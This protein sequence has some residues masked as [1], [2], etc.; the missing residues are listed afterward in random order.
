[1]NISTKSPVI[2]ALANDQANESQRAPPD[3]ASAWRP[4]ADNLRAGL[5]A[6]LAAID[7]HLATLDQASR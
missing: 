6:L 4:C 2:L 1:M 5:P 7:N 3:D